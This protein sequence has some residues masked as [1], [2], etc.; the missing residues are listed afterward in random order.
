VISTRHAHKSG[1]LI[2]TNTGFSDWGNVLYNMTIAT[3]IAHRLVEN[4]EIAA[5]P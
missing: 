4:C 1:S 5:E 3:A 2:T